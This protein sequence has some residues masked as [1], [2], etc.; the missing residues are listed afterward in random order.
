MTGPK[1]IGFCGN[2][3][4]PSKT[5]ALVEAQGYAGMHEVEIFSSHDW[6]KRPPDEVLETCRARHLTCC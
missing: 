6:W 1:V 2:T 5:R 4:R 3:Q